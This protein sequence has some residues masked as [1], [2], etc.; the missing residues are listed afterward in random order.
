MTDTGSAVPPPPSDRPG[1]AYQAAVPAPG[2]AMRV[3]RI[4]RVAAVAALVLAGLPLMYLYALLRVTRI[5]SAKTVA[6]LLARSLS[7]WLRWILW[8]L[9]VRV[10]V[11]GGRFAQP[12]LMVPNHQSYLDILVL[13][14]CVPSI[15]V[16]KADVRD[17]PFFG[18]LTA[19]LGTLYV[20]R[21]RRRTLK[22][23][24][25]LIEERLGWGVNV[26]VFLEGTTSDGT[27]LR[28]FHS[29]FL[30][31]ALHTGTPCL[32]IAIRYATPFDPGPTS[33]SV[34]WWG[35]M[36]FAPHMW[37]LLALRRINV[38]VQLGEPVATS[39]EMDRKAL[40]EEL[41][42]VV[43]DQLSVIGRPGLRS[44]Q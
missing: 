41:R 10:R 19:Y 11:H 13:L 40:A 21:A 38:D 7:V 9:G 20:D 16:S 8:A 27:G 26:A 12:V 14:F 37:R 39:R 42:A 32:P 2:A 34:N 3:V 43:S 30:E 22:A 5:L 23:L 4:V 36:E 31:T 6:R 18:H 44:G 25:P 24:V 33:G 35:G 28:P 29:G 17:W 1:L 15:F